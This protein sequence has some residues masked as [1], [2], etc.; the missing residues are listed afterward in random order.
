[1]DL[2]HYLMAVTGAVRYGFPSSRLTVVGITGTSGKSTTVFLLDAILAYAGHKVGSTSTIEFRVAEK[3]ELNKTKMTQ[4]G[5]WGTQKMLR[6]MVDAK[7]DIAVVETTSQ[8]I[9]QF[10]HIGIEYD[11]ALLTNLYPEHIEAH[12]GFENYKNAKKKLFS[13]LAT[14]A[15]KHV[16]GIPKTSIVNGTVAEAVEFLAPRVERKWSFK[17][18]LAG[19]ERSFISENVLVN[20]E[21]SAFTLDL[22][23]FKIPLP[24]EHIVD[25]ALA[26]IAAAAA[27]G[28]SLEQAAEALAQIRAV[29]GRIEFI[30]VGQPFSVVIDFAFEPVA[31]KNLYKTVFAVPHARVI[32]VLGGTGGG[33]DVARRPLIGNIAGENADL[34]IVTNEDPYDDDPLAIMEQVAAGVRGVGKI[35]DQNLFVIPDRREAIW[36]ALQ[37]AEEHD[38]I[39]VTGKGSEQAI[40]GKNNTLT[41]WD[42]RAVARE[43]LNSLKTKWPSIRT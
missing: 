6:R 40:V 13:Y 21:G 16:F 28:V 37:L 29:P 23:Q 18:T 11:V 12:G 32:H 10:R 4:L 20:S 34:V 41:P 2:Y 25:D 42:D 17:K 1:M 19:C 5:R 38:M 8:G 33:R 15:R 14:R 36:R 27:V 43:G 9:E 3:I 39:L 30:N 31:L 26:A 35:D 24:G 7:C 22:Q